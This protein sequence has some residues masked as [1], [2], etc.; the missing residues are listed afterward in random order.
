MKKRG[1]G[2]GK[3]NGY[4]G[5]ILGD[6]SAKVAAA[7]EV[8]EESGLI[9]EIVD[10]ETVALVEFYFSGDLRV[11]CEV[12]ISRKW[13]NEPGET[14]EMRPQWFLRSDIPYSQMWA[15][16]SRWLPLILG[17]ETISARVD[18]NADGSD[19]TDFNHKPK[20]FL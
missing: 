9:V 19:V 1:F 4:G 5:K 2:A 15:A 17:G 8:I 3:W 16:D 20:T 13:Q 6:E 14:D 7:R 12:F 10:L 11:S 18:F